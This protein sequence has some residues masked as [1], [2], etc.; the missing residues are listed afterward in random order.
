[1][2]TLRRLLPRLLV[3]AGVV[4]LYR[5]GSAVP[6]PMIRPEALASIADRRS[7]TLWQQFNGTP[8]GSVSIFAIGIVPFITGSIVLQ[9]LRSVIPALR[10]ADDEGRERIRRITRVFTLVL[11]AAQAAALV[12]TYRSDRHGIGTSI[13]AGALDALGAG[14]L[15]VGGF[16]LLGL[17]AGAVTRH[18]IGNGVSVLLLVNILAVTGARLAELRSDL[19][20]EALVWGAVLLGGGLLLAV[21]GMRSHH[22]LRARP[23]RLDL[24][25]PGRA[26][27]VRAHILQGGVITITF[28]SAMLG[29]VLAALRPLLG[30]LGADGVLDGAFPFETALFFLLV[31]ALA[32][33]QLRVTLD[34][35]EVANDYARRNYFLEGIRP[36]WPTADA[37]SGMSNSAAI[38]LLSLLLPLSLSSSLGAGL[39]GGITLVVPAA[40]LLLLTSVGVEVLRQLADAV[41]PARTAPALV[42]A[43]AADT[44]W[45]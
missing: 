3:T 27:E 23:G 15:L 34:P 8:L 4:L 31:V 30:V 36:G 22:L 44:P 5:I 13:P 19:T 2:P 12:A 35:V 20:A 32:R 29:V 37:I 39:S 45:G 1:M 42:G 40:T 16:L 38:A 26:V 18:G 10:A 33:L 43:G 41:R 14:V 25:A 11:A 28:A 24:S 17:L 9:L 7:E 21:V 6:L